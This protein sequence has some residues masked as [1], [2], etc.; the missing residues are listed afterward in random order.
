MNKPCVSL[1]AIV[2]EPSDLEVAIRVAQQ[3]LDSESVLSLRP[4]SPRT[5]SR[6]SA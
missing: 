4:G 2:S 3:L 5:R 1:A 6:G